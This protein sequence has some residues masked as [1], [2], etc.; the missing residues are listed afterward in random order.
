MS[1]KRTPR[2]STPRQVDHEMHRAAKTWPQ[3]TYT[4]AKF[5]KARPAGFVPTPR[6]HTLRTRGDHP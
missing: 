1:L 3:R 5:D 4:S 6:P 2:P